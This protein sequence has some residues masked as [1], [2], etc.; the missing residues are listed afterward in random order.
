MPAYAGN[1]MTDII[2]SMMQLFL[3]MMSGGSGLSGFNSYAMNPYGTNPYRFA[4]IGGQGFPFQGNYGGWGG[5][6]YSQYG[7]GARSPYYAP[8]S[9]SYSNPYNSQYS[10]NGSR[11]ADPYYSTYYRYGAD[12]PRRGKTSPVIIQPI[13]VSAGQGSDGTQAPKVEILPAQSVVPAKQSAIAG[14]APYAAV[15][16]PVNNYDPWNYDNPLLGRWQGVNGEFLELGRNR[17]RLRSRNADMRG[18]YQIKNGI[19]K[20]VIIHRPEPIYM[21]YRLARGQLA[22]RSEDGQMMLF[23][24]LN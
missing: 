22:F 8:Y 23:R 20:A 19:M 21:Q 4:G 13:I 17:F 6:P 12:Y 14:K 3:W 16:P 11:Y 15:P 1:G 24:R 5:S 7:Y 10:Y 9:N 2:S 18:R